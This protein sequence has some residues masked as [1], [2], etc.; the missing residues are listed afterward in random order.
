M[1]RQ[2]ARH[3][4]SGCQYVHEKE[5]QDKK[6]VGKFLEMISLSAYSYGVV[7]IHHHLRIL[8]K[9]HNSLAGI[10]RTAFHHQVSKTGLFQ[11]FH[12]FWGNLHVPPHAN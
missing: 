3:V 4:E 5:R 11:M 8:R 12:L 1:K 6:N 9:K 7:F 2:M 10:E